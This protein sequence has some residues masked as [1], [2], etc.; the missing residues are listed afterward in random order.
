MTPSSS[1][2]RVTRRRAPLFGM[3]AAEA[4]SV[5][6]NMLTL[7][8]VPW[9]V[10]QTTASAGKTG[11]T[12]FF[13]TL[14]VILSASLGGALV[15]RWG[16]RRTS[17]AAD[18]ASGVAVALIPLLHLSV[19]LAFWQL[20][21]LVFAGA[22]LDTPG[23]TARGALL[24]ELAAQAGMRLERATSAHDG[25]S[26][27]ARML[28]GPLAGVLIAVMGTTT[29]LFV[30]AATFLVSAI[31]VR[32][33]VPAPG[34]DG[35]AEHPRY[36][37]S[38]REGLGFIS[39]DRLLLAIVVMVMVTNMLDQAMF[40]V[41][42]PVFANSVLGG[43]VQLGAV[44]GT[45]GVG[46]LIGTVVFGAVCHRLPRRITYT[47]GFLVAGCPRWF[48]M[49][50][51]STLPPVLVAVFVGG[52]AA[53]SLNPIIST[54][55]YER[56][57]VG[58]RARAFGVIHAGAWA[59]MPV[60]AVLAGVLVEAVGLRTGLAIGGSLYLLATLSPLVGRSWRAMDAS[61]SKPEPVSLTS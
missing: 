57:P 38:L 46:A 47:V 7:V 22:L 6:G 23:Q 52:L 8:A 9:F 4:I 12:G 60:G 50:T 19:G 42:L 59:A 17:I 31:L 37:D 28:G 55:M 27:G 56:V 34:R 18:L 40:A 43:A 15:D 3:L 13:T 44:L 53:G 36:L 11:L 1:A 10:L 49:A 48:V 30:D 58:M 5:T 16:Y 61:S 39:R 51:S 32:I 35:K 14:P 45:F 24:P 20:L 21:A 54:V 2:S 26:R 33:F 29:V 41:M 25:V